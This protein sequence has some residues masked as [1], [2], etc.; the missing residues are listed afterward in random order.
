MKR[1]LYGVLAIMATFMVACGPTQDDAITFN[2]TLVEMDNTAYETFSDYESAI[3][4]G[5]EDDIEELGAKLQEDIDAGLEYINSDSDFDGPFKESAIAMF[6]AYQVSLDDFF[7]V[8]IEYWTNDWD[9][10][11]EEAEE[12]AYN[13]MYDLIEEKSDDF[14][15][16]Q[17][18][19][20][21]EWDF[22]L[23]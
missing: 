2:D 5:D 16:A 8:M 19:F 18:A 1:V 17:E 3:Y 6:E 4:D 23:E 13:D 15:E 20:A 21:D 11:L 22:I 9:E 14:I 12:D 10:D 7:P